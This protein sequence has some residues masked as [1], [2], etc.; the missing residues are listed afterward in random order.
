MFLDGTR[1]GR[2]KSACLVT[3]KARNEVG[4][5]ACG[6]CRI[7]CG[8][9]KASI[10]MLEPDTDVA[11]GSRF[12]ELVSKEGSAMPLPIS[13][14][15]RVAMWLIGVT[16]VGQS[17]AVHAETNQEL[18]SQFQLIDKNGRQMP[19]T[20]AAVAG[21]IVCS[22][23]QFNDY[24]KEAGALS[25][26]MPSNE[27]QYALEIGACDLAVVRRTGSTGSQT[28]VGTGQSS[29]SAPSQGQSGSAAAQT[30]ASGKNY[31]DCTDLEVS[32]K[33]GD[34]WAY[35]RPLNN[36]GTPVYTFLCFIAGNQTTYHH[37]VERNGERSQPA[38]DSALGGTMVAYL[39]C[40]REGFSSTGGS[41]GASACG[42]CGFSWMKAVQNDPYGD[43]KQIWDRV[44]TSECRG[45]AA[46]VSRP[47]QSR[48]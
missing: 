11:V 9:G 46:P 20:P 12:L 10:P 16:A 27:R 40:S 31:T 30:G 2:E 48:R 25:A 34:S 15:C 5:E 13:E 29:A 44:T 45:T 17:L 36:C 6:V 23:M 42:K 3:N 28:G 19:L 47:A 35:I 22:P 32:F 21:K 4:A 7:L 41:P 37:C 14:F 18:E 26:F 38:V 43:P 8:R 33:P 24:L 1:S 39:S